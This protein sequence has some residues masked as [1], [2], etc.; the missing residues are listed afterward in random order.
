MMDFL[1]NNRGNFMLFV[2]ILAAVT[3]LVL[4]KKYKH[5]AAKYFIFFLVYT[6]IIVFVGKYT[7]YVK[8]D[9]ILSFLDGTVLERNY[10]WYT[11][12]WKIGAS[13]FFGF[14]YSKILVNKVLKKILKFSVFF[15]L[16]ISIVIILFNL[17]LYF[18]NSIPS[19]SILSALIIF[20]CVFFYFLEILQ[21]DKILSFYTSLN[22]YISVAILLF[23]LIKTPLTFFEPYYTK[24]DEDYVHLRSCI[25]LGV[26]SFM[27]ITYIIGLIVSKPEYD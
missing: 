23:W 4:Y 15:F 6:V 24:I 20:Q 13:V 26:I 17:P 27:Y 7:H 12:F 19:I 25:N 21:S 10:W 16:F 18:T 11:L 8:N 9:G 22:F 3:G 1:I 2:E 5:T 14:Y